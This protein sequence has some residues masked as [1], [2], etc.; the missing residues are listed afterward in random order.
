MYFSVIGKP[1]ESI[2]FVIENQMN[3]PSENNSYINDNSATAGTREINR[4]PKRK[5]Q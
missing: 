5:F 2:F 4:A 1:N 3:P